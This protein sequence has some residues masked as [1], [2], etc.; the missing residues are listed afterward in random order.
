VKGILE[1]EEVQMDTVARES[2]RERAENQ[3]D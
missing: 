1:V 2:D 3:Y